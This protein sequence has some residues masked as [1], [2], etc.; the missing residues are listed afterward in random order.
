MT[1]LP[2]QGRA[3]GPNIKDLV[4]Q[5]RALGLHALEFEVRWVRVNGDD[6]QL[7]LAHEED[8]SLIQH[9]IRA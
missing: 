7:V 2:S 9:M 3:R 4:L 5:R 8:L 1:S 6:A